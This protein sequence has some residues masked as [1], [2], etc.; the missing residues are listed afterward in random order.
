[1]QLLKKKMSSKGMSKE[2]IIFNNDTEKPIPSLKT[3]SSHKIEDNPQYENRNNNM[4][5]RRD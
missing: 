5:P 3:V 2:K 4:P 1:M